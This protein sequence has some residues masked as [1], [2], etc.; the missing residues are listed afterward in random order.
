MKHYQLI[1]LFIALAICSSASSQQQ[2]GVTSVDTSQLLTFAKVEKE[3]EFPGGSNAW[4][5]FLTKI[6]TILRRHDER[7]SRGWSCCSL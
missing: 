5:E 7:I 1:A 2:V 6:Y 3:S 4:V